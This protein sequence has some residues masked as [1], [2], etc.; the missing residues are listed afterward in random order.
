MIF[1]ILTMVGKINDLWYF[2]YGGEKSMIFGI[3]TMVGKINDF[4]Y[5]DY[6]KNH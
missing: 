5:F 4:W 2:D 1:G 6:T 3:L